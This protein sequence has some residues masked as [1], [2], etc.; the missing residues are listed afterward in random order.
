MKYFG[1]FLF[2][3][4]ALSTALNI[5]IAT[6]VSKTCNNDKTIKNNNTVNIV[7]SSIVTILGLFLIVT[8]RD[9][10]YSKFAF[11]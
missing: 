5:I 9:E 3:I 2:V 6:K 7:L 8:Q 11:G 1:I 10:S 4:G